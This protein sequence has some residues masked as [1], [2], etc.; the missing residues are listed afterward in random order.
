VCWTNAP[1]P[2][3]ERLRAARDE[4]EV[5]GVTFQPEVSHR[6]REQSWGA[7]QECG[8]V[9]V[10]KRLSKGESKASEQAGLLGARGVRGLGRL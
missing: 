8:A 2:Q 10:W 5:A 6:A 7:V 9:P 1:N 4:E 3:E